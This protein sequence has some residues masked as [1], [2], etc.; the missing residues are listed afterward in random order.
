MDAITLIFLIFSEVLI[1]IIGWASLLGLPILLPY[2]YFRV[3]PKT[4]R[5]FIAAKR[6]NMIPALI[7][8]DS[9]RAII[10]LVREKMG[11]GICVTEKGRYKCLPKYVEAEEVSKEDEKAAF[12]DENKVGDTENS[13]NAARK[14]TLK[15]LVGMFGDWVTKRCIL[16]GLG[17]PMLLGYSGKGCLLNPLALALWEAGKLKIRDHNHQFIRKKVKDPDSNEIPDIDDLLQPLM[18]LDARASKAVISAAYDEAQI[19]AMCSDSEQIGSIGRGLP[20]WVLP[21][22]IILI[23]V[24]GL[25][26]LFLILTGVIPMG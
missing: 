16:V 7:V 3:F 12:P 15:K 19:A 9:G 4:A 21:V 13:K 1:P 22:G 23:V 11:G 8:H 25:A 14:P 10:T 26:L 5:T 17:K 20:K 2:V 24:I 18:F 6:K